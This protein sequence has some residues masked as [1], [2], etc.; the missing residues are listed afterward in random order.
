MGPQRKKK[1]ALHLETCGGC[2]EK[3]ARHREL[4]RRYREFERQSIASSASRH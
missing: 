3:V 2:R 4:A 1:I